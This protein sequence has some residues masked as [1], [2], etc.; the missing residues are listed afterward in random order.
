[1]HVH[2]SYSMCT[3]NGIGVLSNKCQ[4]SMYLKS[5]FNNFEETVVYLRVQLQKVLYFI[6]I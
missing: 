5:F 1:M 4:K 3:F 2:F 6:V